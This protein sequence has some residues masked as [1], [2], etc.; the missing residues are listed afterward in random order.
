MKDLSL[1]ILDIVQN[2]IKAKA[3]VIE[4]SIKDVNNSTLDV[5]IIDNGSGIEPDMLKNIAD[6]YTTSRTTRKVGLGIPLFKQ[7][8]ERTGGH[9]TITSE[10]G[11]GTELTAQFHQDNIDCLPLGD[12]SGVVALLVN[13]NPTIDFKYTHTVDNNTYIFNTV[14]V[15]E[16]LGDTPIN[17]TEV[18]LFIKEMIKENIE[19]LY[20]NKLT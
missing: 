5:D 16:V 19:E 1:H 10:V 6:P 4:I 13:A 9:L 18:H 17:S 14:E 7:N 3:T 2:A 12:V 20:N 11:K 8:A 15:K